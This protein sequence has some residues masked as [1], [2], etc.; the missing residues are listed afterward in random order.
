MKFDIQDLVLI[1]NSKYFDRNWYESEYPDVIKSK[2]APAVHFLRI[3]AHLG[4]DPG[5]NF[6]TQEYL[7]ANP[8]VARAKVNALL[9]YERSGRQEGRKISLSATSEADAPQAGIEKRPTVDVIV[10]IYNALEDVKNCIASLSV[11]KTNYR[12]RLILINDYSDKETTAWL[13]TAVKEFSSNNLEIYLEEN[14]TN[15]G[16][17][18][19]V[20]VGLRLSKAPFIVTLNSDTIVTSFWLDGLINCLES[21]SKIGIVG[22]LSNAATWQNVPSLYDEDGR[23]SIQSLPDDLTPEQM[24]KLVRETSN[25]LYPKTNFVN[26]FCFMFP[27]TVLERVGFLDEQAFPTGYGEE[28]DFCIR[29]IDEGFELA[30][31]D[32]VYVYHAKSKSFGSD[33]RELLS[34]AGGKAL[35]EKH[36]V[37][38]MRTLITQM[39]E[40]SEMD[41]IRDNVNA[42]LI[43]R[44]KDKAVTGSE[45]KLNPSGCF[46]EHGYQLNFASTNAALRI[47]ANGEESRFPNVSVGVHLHLHYAEY[48]SE[49]IDY[50]LNIPTSFSLYISVSEAENVEKIEQIFSTGVPNANVIVRCFPNR[51]RDIGPFV[52]GF[53]CEILT[54]DLVCHIHSKRSPHNLAKKDWRMQLLS[55]LLASRAYV[56]NIFR[57]FAD[58]SKIGM[59]FP[60]YHWSLRD[61]ISWGTN[62]SKANHLARLMN[63]N[64]SPVRLTPFPA[65]SMFWAKSDALKPLFNLGMEFSDFPDEEAQVDGTTAHAIERLFGE[66]VTSQGY[67]VQQIKTDKPYNIRNYFTKHWPYQKLSNE[68]LSSITEN[69]RQERE[70][71]EAKA[72][73][74]CPNIGAYD[75]VVAHECLEANTDYLLVSDRELPNYGQWITKR[76]EVQGSNTDTARS[77]KTSAP[78]FLSGYDVGIWIDANVLITGSIQSFIGL[79]TMYPD[80]PIFGIQHPHRDCIY[81]EALAVV[82]AKK[83]SEATVEAQMNAYARDGYP[84]KN[85]LI[86]TNFMVLNMKHE[87][88]G[89]IFEAWR[90]EL[91][92]HTHRDQLSLNYVLWKLDQSWMPIMQEGE[93]LRTHKSFAYFGHSRNSGYTSPTIPSQTIKAR[94]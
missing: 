51:G 61:Q 7:K 17:T 4:R 81:D 31:A 52:T 59:L 38:R 53:G 83:A 66:I 72:C 54:H 34:Q 16:Y 29:A 73:V 49:F 90:K 30:Y 68:E 25:T 22:P 47:D 75:A 40:T 14:K 24:G 63:L 55:N 87:M 28:N 41:K 57:I 58:N 1:E 76:I 69:Y 23:H 19:S 65:G 46:A 43:R 79:P 15:L 44:E 91:R 71:V 86:E 48:A 39:S 92:K 18:K 20:N 11:A 9:H 8:D 74:L 82:K 80:V 6:S 62:K 78:D 42:A 37:E 33:R 45:V 12:S 77:I 64:L 93:N 3:G 50:L 35:R 89:S 84:K 88:L 67:E 60:E 32:D 10:P 26:G 2:I 56:S 70:K 94:K 13:R 85:G 21:N 36:G 27:R 5:P